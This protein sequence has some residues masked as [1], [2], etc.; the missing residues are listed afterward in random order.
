MTTI[1]PDL[2][3][4]NISKLPRSL[5]PS[6]R[7]A[8]GPSSWSGIPDGFR[9]QIISLS[10]SG[11]EE[12][13]G[14]LPVFYAQLDPSLIPSTD[15]WDTL[16]LTHSTSPLCIKDSSLTLVLLAA[17]AHSPWF[18][19]A[20]TADL[21]P[22][23]WKWVEFLSLYCDHTESR[24]FAMEMYPVFSS[25][26]KGFSEHQ[27]TRLLMISTPGIR[28][29]L[30]TGWTTLLHAFDAERETMGINTQLRD[31]GESLAAWALVRGAQDLPEL[32]E[33]CGGTRENLR[34]ALIRTISLSV[35]Y[36]PNPLATSA[37]TGVGLLLDH[38]YSTSTDIHDYLRS[39]G[40]IPALVPALSVGEFSPSVGPPALVPFIR[41]LTGP[42]SISQYPLVVQ[43]LRAGLLSQVIG[44][45]ETMGANPMPQD[46]A[47]PQ[48]LES[49]LPQTLVYYP[50]VVEMKK[51]F[52]VVELLAHGNRFSRSALYPLWINLKALVDRR[53]K[54]LEAWD[55]TG[56]PSSLACHNLECDTAD[57]REFFQR[58]SAC[59]TA[60]YCSPACQRADWVDGHREDCPLLRRAHQAQ[61]QLG[62]RHRDKTFIRALL[63]ADY[64]R[65]RVLI[66]IHM[67]KFIARNPDTSFYVLFDYTRGIK[68]NIS[69]VC[70][71]PGLTGLALSPAWAAR[72]ARA[73]GC[74]VLHG[75]R[76]GNGFTGRC[77]TLIWPLRA[78]SSAFYD[79]LREIARNWNGVESTEV[80]G[81][82]RDLVERTKSTELHYY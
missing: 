37:L 73:G 33:G 12:G 32:L 1:H 76:I 50:A 80:E 20:T 42:G 7:R 23:V 60:A 56:R 38:G 71:T 34:L 35:T 70:S 31:I 28:R 9:R 77:V 16:D 53:A 64:Q 13:L 10:L 17:R 54:M 48:L 44:W 21:W 68:L 41:L 67:V 62:M 24:A 81:L 36:S 19:L 51:A 14:L 69:V 6:A 61:D 74:L 63:S 29:L 4:R 66:A 46:S 39:N 45:G 78:T 8:M 82:V 52:S 55:Y 3:P 27:P 40:L 11:D 79:G 30:A 49:I 43:A 72:A 22:R 59:F 25:I 47:L 65:F 2:L 15:F 26:V 58:C 5:Q 18:P 75:I 57:E